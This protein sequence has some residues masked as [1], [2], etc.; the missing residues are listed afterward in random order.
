MYSNIVVAFD[1]SEFA[2]AAL[3]E[4]LHMVKA[5]GGS[6]TMARA[7][8]FDTE[9]FG[10]APEQ[11]EKRF[12]KARAV[13][14]KSVE[15]YSTEFGV[16]IG[17]SIRQGDAPEVI[18]EVAK[19]KAA[20]LVVMG[21][22]GRR[23]IKRLIMGSTT[24]SVLLDAPCDVLVVKRPCHECTGK[25]DSVLV[26]FDGS[27]PARKALARAVDMA[28]TNGARLIALYVIPQYEEMIEFYSS[29]S[30]NNRLIEEGRKIVDEAHKIAG[31]RGMD[32]ATLVEKGRAG[33]VIAETAATLPN[34]VIVM[35]TRAL[36]GMN[37]AILGSTAERVIASASAPILVVKG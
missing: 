34:P 11:L 35:G 9:E 5:H 32:A 14:M 10:I 29:A 8:Y 7:V 18:I 13:C 2:A 17:L 24:S 1:E 37:K 19:E 31:G 21:T 28:K 23:G 4:A 36:R 20:D 22:Y 12:N 25:Y 33:D 6:V 27:Q 15:R 16:S 3:V 26:P 30:I